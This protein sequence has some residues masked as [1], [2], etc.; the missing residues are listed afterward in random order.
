MKRIMLQ[1][2]LSTMV[3]DEDLADLE[4]YSWQ[5][6]PCPSGFYVC[7]SAEGTTVYM[8]R[9]LKGCPENLDVDHRDG[10]SLNNQKSNLREATRT[11]NNRNMH[12]SARQR[13]GAFKGIRWHRQKQRWQARIT[14]NY[15][16]LCVGY[17]RDALAAAL[18][19]DSAALRVFGEFAAPN[20]SPSND[21]GAL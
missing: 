11:Q 1:S 9:Q 10:N 5:A 2:G 6:V 21:R 18:L 3:D 19:Y 8:H 17:H 13:R 12:R 16:S 7:R 4:R 20:F 14:V 15:K